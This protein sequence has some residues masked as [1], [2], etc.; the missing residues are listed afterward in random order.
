MK[1]RIWAYS[2]LL[3]LFGTGLVTVVN[4][5]SASAAPYQETVFVDS[6]NANPVTTTAVLQAGTPYSVTVSG[7]YNIGFDNS[8]AD[9]ECAT[10]PPDSTYQSKRFVAFDPAGDIGDLYVAGAAVDWK[11]TKA[12]AFGC[13]SANH[14]YTTTYTPTTS[15]K[16]SLRV[17]DTPGGGH[18]DNTGALRVVVADARTLVEAVSVPSN[19]RDGVTTTAIL[20][21][22]K[23]YQ[24]EISGEYIWNTQ[25]PPSKADAECVRIGTKDTPLQPAGIVSSPGIPD[26]FGAMTPTDP[27]D[28]ILD[29]YVNGQA[30]AW[31]P[32]PAAAASGLPNSPTPLGCDDTNRTYS[33]TFKPA[34]ATQLNLAVRDNV[35]EDNSGS[36]SA[37]VYEVPA[38]TESSQLQV[39]L[40]EVVLAEEIRVDSRNPSGANAV[41]ALQPGRNYL[42]EAMGTFNWGAGVADAECTTA[43]GDGIYIP[44]RFAFIDPNNDIADLVINNRSIN[45]QPT[46][47]DVEGCNTTDHV[48]RTAYSPSTPGLTNFK[49]FDGVHQDNA[50]ELI[51][52]VYL[53]DEA[54]PTGQEVDSFQVF[55]ASP[56]GTN[57][58]VV[59]SPANDYAFVISGSYNWNNSLPPGTADAECLRVTGTPGSRE[60]ANA[61]AP[62]ATGGDFLDVYV[63]GGAVDWAPTKASPTGCNDVDQTY[64]VG[65]KPLVSGKVNLR[66]NDT[67][68]SD[69]A[70]SLR[71]KILKV[72]SATPPASTALPKVSL[73]EEVQVDSRSATGT[74]SKVPVRPGESLILEAA[75]TY[76]WGGGRADAECSTSNADPVWVQNR[77]AS[78]VPGSD[79]VDVMVDNTSVNWVAVDPDANGC[80]PSNTYKLTYSPPAAGLLNFKMADSVLSDNNGTV[81]VKIYRIDEIPVGTY[82][83]NATAS[84]G[85]MTAPFLAGKTY[86]VQAKGTYVFWNDRPNSTNLGDAECTT[87]DGTTYQHDRYG[88]LLPSQD[89]G[90]LYVN[91][92]KVTWTPATGA[93]PCDPNNV[94]SYVFQAANNG[95]GD[96]RIYD[97]VYH[98][99]A[100][101]LTVDIF[102]KA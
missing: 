39:P 67:V 53:I 42:I 94:Y 2:S 52:R 22:A 88:Y 72:A 63:N 46:I 79:L 68:H 36:M 69:N 50:G 85:H 92:D 82:K 65:F 11:P 37:K 54:P 81:T 62:F 26:F 4:P 83:V 97:T 29:V 66:V 86:R 101:E 31:Q 5:P 14:T 91:L 43:P 35:Y 13:N 98:D 78:L 102:M 56:G 58:N 9:A 3:A 40:P 95:S 34:A 1:K 21:P 23:S 90:D 12:D 64:T 25:V 80:S 28:D 70:G 100:G 59:L 71:V 48:Y 33:Y 76:V 60:A 8:T 51:V 27:A 41:S 17:H 74:N 38:G 7:T 55:G 99:N 44:D 45:W 57:S 73:V 24:I 96:L 32:K 19:M 49:I 6:R 93:G 61:L 84:Q 20:D 18:N 87:V 15:G 10:L 16:L 30:V 75:G 77:F 89:L 47:T